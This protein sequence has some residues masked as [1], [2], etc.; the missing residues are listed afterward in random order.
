MKRWESLKDYEDLFKRYKAK[1]FIEIVNTEGRIDEI[2]EGL[3]NKMLYNIVVK[4]DGN[5]IV[6]FVE[7]T[8]IECEI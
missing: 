1:Q 4:E 3:V 5:L 2:D 7:G 8:E 6:R